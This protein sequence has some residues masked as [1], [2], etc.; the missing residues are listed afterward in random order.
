M[1]LRCAGVNDG[2]DMD[3]DLFTTSGPR[4]GEA[5]GTSPPLPHD[6][7]ERW[8]ARFRAARV[9]LPRWARLAPDRSVFV[10]NSVGRYEVYAW[11]RSTGAQ[12]QV[13]DRR[14][15]TRHGTID[16]SGRQ[17]WWFDDHDGDE[18]GVWRHQSF[19]GGADEVAVPGLSPSYPAGLALGRD[20]TAIVGRTTDEGTRVHLRVPGREVATL[21][22]HREAAQVAGLSWDGTLAAIAHSEHGDS[23][24]PAV[25]VFR[26]EADGGATVVTD[27]WDGPGKGL[28]PVGFPQVDGDE[29]LLVLHERRGRTEPMLWHPVTGEQ[30]ELDL[31]LPGEMVADWYPDGSALL[32]LHDHQARTTL[33]RYDLASGALVPVGPHDGT[34]SDATTR[35]DGSVEYLWSSTAEPPV[36]RSTT[37]AVVL[38]PPGPAP[39]R[40]VPAEDLDVDGPGGRIHSLLCRP[41]A[42]GAPYPALFLVHGGPTHHDTDSFAADVAAWVDAGFAVVLVNYRGSDGYGTEWRDAISARVGLTELE[43]LRAV[44]D[45][46]VSVGL[47]DPSRVVLSGGS[48]G[49][50]LTL[51]GLGTQPDAWSL[52][53]AGVPVADYVAAYEDEMEGLRAFDRSLFGGSPAEVPERYR[54]SSPITY[55]ESVR[56]PVLILA[57][58]NDPRCP[59]RQID[60]Y[61]TRLRE[62]GREHQVHLFDAGHGSLVV[63]E[64]IRQMEVQLTFALRHLG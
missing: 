62:L 7:Q 4:R 45:H 38:T 5:G 28:Q 35:P 37:G 50:Y 3:E 47:F 34:V 60:N 27:L 44:R 48:W 1:R 54:E 19:S 55:V 16:P 40:S 21:Y 46:G 23:R 49:G 6:A 64:Q 30:R 33:L 59:M 25:R 17:I 53:I 10:S 20:G 39:P 22:T 14:E 56:A 43:D 11:D 41:D 63:E 42:V 26:I 31:G 58:A 36:V 24:H 12:R 52:G 32:V 15:G 13:T 57:G 8:K 9:T 18:F 61:L 2:P 51:L 29:R